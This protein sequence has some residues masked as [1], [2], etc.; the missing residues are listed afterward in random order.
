MAN[1]EFSAVFNPLLESVT[2][3]VFGHY[4]T[5]KPGEVKQ[6][7]SHMV[8][9]I[10]L[11]RREE[12]LVKVEDPRFIPS[13]VDHYIPGFEKTPEGQAVLK[14]YRERGIN[15]YIE[16]L[17][18]VVRNNQVALR[19]DLADRYPTGDSG[20][21]AAAW[22]SK[23]E[24]EAMRNVVKYKGKTSDNAA[25]QIEEVE[26]IMQQVGPMVV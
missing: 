11:N 14:P 9:F 22:A 23:G 17:M 21:M 6:L 25:K 5:W 10:D 18:D 12:G 15:S 13:E 1:T 3:R 8:D 24:L 16:K 20:K 26:K 19:Q 2:T 7:R 4:F